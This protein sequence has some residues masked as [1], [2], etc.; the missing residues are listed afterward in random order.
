MNEEQYAFGRTCMWHAPLTFAKLADQLDE[1]GQE[2]YVCPKCGLELVVTTP[3]AFWSTARA[4]EK[5][6]PENV[7]MLRWSEG[8]CFQDFRMMQDAY[9]QAME[10]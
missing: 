2:V 3:A 1:R 6:I 8:K 9:R 4:C 7:E 5:A 10:E